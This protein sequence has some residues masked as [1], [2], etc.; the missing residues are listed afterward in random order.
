MAVTM[1]ITS[2]ADSSLQRVERNSSPG[3]RAEVCEPAVPHAAL[4]KDARLVFSA[5]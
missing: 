4:L 2:A 5:A 3:R 1:M